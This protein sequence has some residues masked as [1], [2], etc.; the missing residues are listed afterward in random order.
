MGWKTINCSEI[1]EEY[2]KVSSREKIFSYTF[3][4]DSL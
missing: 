4:Q 2:L 1:L 3:K